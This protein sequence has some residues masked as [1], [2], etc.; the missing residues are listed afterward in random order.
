[1]PYALPVPDRVKRHIRETIGSK[2]EVRK[3]APGVILQGA[4]DGDWR[5]SLWNPAGEPFH[6][7]KQRVGRNSKRYNRINYEY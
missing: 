5:L 7:G 3:D 6:A 1:M 4:G 2:T